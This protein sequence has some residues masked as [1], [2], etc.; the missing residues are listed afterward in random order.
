MSSNQ[1]EPAGVAIGLVPIGGELDY[2][3]ITATGF[4]TT[5]FGTPVL[6]RASSTGEGGAG[7]SNPAPGAGSGSGLGDQ[8]CVPADPPALLVPPDPP[9]PNVQGPR[10]C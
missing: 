2:V 8:F 10:T 6:F 1:I 5:T 4:A 9:T 3:F 7:S